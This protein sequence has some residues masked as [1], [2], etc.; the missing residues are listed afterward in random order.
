MILFPI[1]FIA[2]VILSVVVALALRS[3]GREE[4][5]VEAMLD[6]PATHTL[7]YVVPDGQDPAILSAALHRA[8]FEARAHQERGVEIL[9][10]ACTEDRRA[11]VRRVIEHVDSTG[12]DGA[13]LHVA[14]VRFADDA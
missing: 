10:I 13:P 1:I 3:W 4:A 14:R 9:R 8:G 11:E 12:F 2:V 5:R 6:S 7:A